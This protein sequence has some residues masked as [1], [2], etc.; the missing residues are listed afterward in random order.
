[1]AVTLGGRAP[2]APASAVIK[3]IEKHRSG[4][5]RTIDAPALTRIGISEALAPRTVQALTLLDFVD[6]QGHVRPA[7]DGLRT[8]PSDQ[9]KPL[10]ADMLR[11]AYAD[12][13]DIID[14]RNASPQEIADAFRGFE[15]TGQLPR[16]VQLFTGLLSYA[17][18]MPEPGKR[19]PGP[20]RVRPAGAATR[21]VDRT[22]PAQPDGDASRQAAAVKPGVTGYTKTVQL[23][24][25]GT[26]T[27][28]WDVNFA[29]SS[30]DDE[31]FVLG[32]VRQLRRY[33][34]GG[35]ETATGEGAP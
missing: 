9:F 6:D 10:L 33:Q 7:F 30:D 13:L 34:S 15:P 21:E 19:R 25:G 22:D 29:D 5:L 26:V 23:R 3:V 27:L 12:V 32:L 11:G 18:M 20:K 31:D 14:P 16:I 17:E 24:S 8:A 28:A 4:T 2:Y 35:T 1:V